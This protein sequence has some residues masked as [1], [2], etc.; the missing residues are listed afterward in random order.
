MFVGLAHRTDA[1]RVATISRPRHVLWQLICNA[2]V[3]VRSWNVKAYVESW[4]AYGEGCCVT[5]RYANSPS[6]ITSDSCPNTT[7]LDTDLSRSQA[8]R[9]DPSKTPYRL[10]VQS[11]IWP[12]SIRQIRQIVSHANDHNEAASRCPWIPSFS[13]SPTIV[14]DNSESIRNGRRHRLR[15][16]F[17]SY[18]TVVSAR[19]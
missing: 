5:A 10:K 3:C 6:S 13:F 19:S 8:I 17:S 15:G 11:R 9:S 1:H 14:Y 4:F 2:S 12:T 16:R 18:T 7:R